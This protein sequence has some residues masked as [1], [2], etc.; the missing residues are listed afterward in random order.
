[1]ATKVPVLAAI[2]LI[3]AAPLGAVAQEVVAADDGKLEEVVVTAE[4]RT[5]TE[6]KTPIA[7]SVFSADVLAQNGVSSIQDLAAIAPSVNFADNFATAIV[8]IRGVSSR[9]TTEI[10]DPAVSINIDG[11]YFQRAIGLGDTIFDL[12][13][14]EVLRGP[15]GTLYGRNATGG[16][17]NFITAKP[18]S[19]FDAYAGVGFGNY[20][21]IRTEGMLN[22]PLSDRVQMRASF[23][24][25]THDGYGNNA[26]A[27]DA[28]DADSQAGRLHFAFQPTEQLD[29]LLTA[30]MVRLGGIGNM[31]GGMPLIYDEGGN[32]VME[33]PP[34]LPS[35]SRDF[36][37][38]LPDGFLDVT[39]TS[40]RARVDYDFGAVGLTYMGGYR[41]L[42]FKNLIDLDGTEP[43]RFYFQQNEKPETWNHELR[44]FSNNDGR[45]NWQA[46]AFYFK[47][48][49]DLL[50]YFQD[51]SPANSPA[52]LFIFTYPDIES[53]SK[54][55]FGQVSIGFTDALALELGARYSE[56]KKVR[57]GSLNYGSGV[58]IQDAESTSSKPSYHVGLNWQ[59]NDDQLLYAKWGTGYKAGGFTDAAAYDPEEISA[60]EIGSKNRLMNA[61]VQLNVDAYYYDYTDQQISQ[62]VGN[63]TLIR[64]AGE[65]EIYGIE[66]EGAWIFTQSDRIDGYLGYMSAEFTEFN[67]ASGS[68]NVDY[69]GNHPPQAPE[70]SANLGYQHTFSLGN[71]GSLVARAQTH[72][73]SESYL[74]F[75]NTELERQ[76]SYTRTDA[77]LT[78]SAPDDQWSVQG[79]VRNIEDE[80]VFTA[81][82]EQ[83]LFGTYVFQYGAPRTY[84]VDFRINW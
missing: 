11:L 64:N 18:T 10:G 1:M 49:N 53:E 60:F 29:I 81:A 69:A 82:S 13:R 77:L 9:D 48:T 7:M 5:S 39:S 72:Y 8:T 2:G 14:A 83:P 75:R 55:V 31:V 6:Q 16:A 58:L 54:A 41:D 51:Y 68:G 38:S 57:H 22:V 21:L 33:K 26:P 12:E 37:L 4:K 61:T 70:F 50:T 17:I 45:F 3:A 34:G 67:V 32:I 28:D 66:V 27:R 79:Y 15:Q 35:E 43:L 42:D 65:S 76:P 74:G 59:L 71:G 73:E 36:P 40:F 56:D 19:D 78:Y 84:G 23:A 30:E 44:L 62:F 24:T 47:E 46:G 80:P 20:N 52:N 63:Q 25:R